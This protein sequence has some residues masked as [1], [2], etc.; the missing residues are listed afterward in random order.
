MSLYLENFGRMARLLVRYPSAI[1]H[2]IAGMSATRTYVDDLV[3]KDW[4]ADPKTSKITNGFELYLNPKDTYA[5]ALI[6]ITGNYEPEVTRIFRKIVKPGNTVLD[7]GANLGW[8][9]LLSSRIVGDTG[10][11]VS[12]EPE[13]TTFSLL[14][15]SVNKNGIHNVTLLREVASDVDGTYSLDLPVGENWGT[16]SIKRHS[17]ESIVVPSSRVD[18]IIRRLMIDQI[19][20]AKIDVEGGEPEVL[21]GMS[22]L[23]EQN[24]VVRMIMEWNPSQWQANRDLWHTILDRYR[25]YRINSLSFNRLTRIIEDHWPESQANLFFEL[26]DIGRKGR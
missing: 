22:S 11:V 17:T 18:T 8:F 13:P 4:L 10:R 19:D 20:L 1:P 6:G 2:L 26:D 25:V 7:V 12:F 16:S 21:R 15:K 14:E 24:K 5:S 3:R 23:I 9:S